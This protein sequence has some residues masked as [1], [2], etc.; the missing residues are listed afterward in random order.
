M[1][2][3]AEK[4][5]EIS[6]EIRYLVI[7]TSSKDGKPWISPVFYAFD[8]DYNLYWVSSKNS[9]HSELI[10]E[11]P[12]VAVVIFN[13]TKGEG[14]GD[15]V[16]IEANVQELTD[17][18]EIEEAMK[19]YDSRAS[20][21]ELRVKDPQPEQGRRDKRH[22]RRQ[23]E[24]RAIERLPT[25]LEVEQHGQ[26][27]GDDDA[28]GNCH[29]RHIHGIAQ[30]RVED[31]VLRQQL[32]VVVKSYPVARLQDAVRGKAV[33]DRGENRVGDEEQKPQDARRG[34]E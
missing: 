25:H 21:P 23:V 31:R 18:K 33:V 13:S 34:E 16:Y 17:E 3:K 8:D 20:K 30:R 4:A 22:D 14:K 10:R 24:D 29:Q 12:K 2:N 27:H 32:T 7:A 26:A 5:E 9:R 15:A 11:N 19:F 28:Q 6:K 1:E